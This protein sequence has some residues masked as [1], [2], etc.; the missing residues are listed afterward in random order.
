VAAERLAPGARRAGRPGSAALH[1]GAAWLQANPWLALFLV[2]LLSLPA[3][4]TRL[5]ASDEIEY[6]A[7]LR[8]V[9]FDGD[10]RFENGPLLLQPR[11]HRD[12]VQT[13]FLDASG[14]RTPASLGRSGRPSTKRRSTWRQA[15]AACRRWLGADVS[16]DGFSH[17]AIAVVRWP[18]TVS[19]TRAVRVRRPPCGGATRTLLA[20]WVG[21]PLLFY[22]PWP[23]CAASAFSVAAFVATWLVV[24][25]HWSWRG[26]A[27]LGAVMG[28]V[29]EQD[30]FIAVGP[31]LTTS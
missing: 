28:M 9:W 27:A 20:V 16:A 26:V 12:S 7:Y 24:R 17:P 19:G 5:Y 30:P 18:S 22:M 11:Y 13:T 2:F 21:T 29:R 31:Q 14:D 25:R 1:A 10:L 6:F 8:S 23:V 4:T 3:V 15:A